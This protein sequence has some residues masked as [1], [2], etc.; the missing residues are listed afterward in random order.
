MSEIIH[1]NL[2]YEAKIILTPDQTK[3]IKKKKKTEDQ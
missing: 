3:T 1:P 2:F